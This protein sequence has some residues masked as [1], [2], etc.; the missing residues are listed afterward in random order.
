MIEKR[1]D[2]L[3]AS[4]DILVLNLN[5]GMDAKLIYIVNLYNSPA[6]CAR[7]REAVTAIFGGDTLTQ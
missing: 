4:P 6:E 2:L 7:E 3:T 5:I 1:Q